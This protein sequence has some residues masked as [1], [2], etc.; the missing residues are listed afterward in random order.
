LSDYLGVLYVKLDLFHKLFSAIKKHIVIRKNDSFFKKTMISLALIIATLFILIIVMNF[1]DTIF[2]FLIEKNI[3]SL[4]YFLTDGS[5]RISYISDFNF[6]DRIFL[7]SYSVIFYIYQFFNSFNLCAMHPYPLKVDGHLPIEYYGSG[8]LLLLIVLSV[9]ILLVRKKTNRKIIIFGSLFFLIN[10]FIVGHIFPLQGR[11]VT[12][13]RYSYLAYFGLFLLVGFFINKLVE[14]R[15]LVINRMILFA[16]VL[17]LSGYSVYSFSRVGVWKNTNTFWSDVVKKQPDNYYA[18]YGVG[19]Y[20][21]EQHNYEQA[22]MDFTKSVALND[23]DPVVYNNLGRAYNS[24]KKY[25]DAI[26]NFSKAIELQPDFSQFYN[27]RGNAYY[28][29]KDFEKAMSDYKTSIAKWNKNTDALI[30]KGDLE[31]E[32]DQKDSAL[33]D[34]KICIKIDSNNAL[35]FERLGVLYAKFNISDSAIFYLKKSLSINPDFTKAKDALEF[36]ESKPSKSSNTG[37]PIKNKNNSE[38]FVNQ[39]LI[40]AKANDFT[41]AIE[42]FN[43]AITEDSLNATAYKN[44]GN[45]KAALKDYKGSIED[46]NVAIRIDPKDGGA[47]LNRGISKFH[48]DDK[49]ACEDWKKAEQLGSKRAG[50]LLLNHCK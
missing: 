24:V 9:I 42:L 7:F 37:I 2:N 10:V 1:L 41:S 49:T 11:I 39:G 19:N 32:L 20:Q 21:I 44:R 15:N 33:A 14:K 30:N 46:F 29:L 6:V 22:I 5:N 18:Y 40:K 34:Y 48:L 28:Y 36:V 3:S 27:N 17:L 47:Y 45:A 50:D 13:D 12:A 35:P 43:K 4:T 8:A 25:D 16:F 26:K 31:V 38:N 23:K